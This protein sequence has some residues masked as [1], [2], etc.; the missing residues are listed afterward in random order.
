M[1]RN[2][3]AEPA[4]IPSRRRA[5]RLAGVLDER[6]AMVGATR[7]SALQVRDLAVEVN[8]KDEARAPRDRRL[9]GRRVEVA[10]VLG[11]VDDD[12]TR[13]RLRDRLE[14]GHERVRGDDHLVPGPHPRASSPSRSASRPLARPTQCA[15]PQ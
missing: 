2:S 14:R 8:G 1:R 12:G 5:V 10:V 7:S 13:A 11:D 3:P 4:R 6:E 15:L 9:G